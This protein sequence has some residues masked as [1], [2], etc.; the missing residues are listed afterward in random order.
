MKEGNS[1]KCKR[2]VTALL[3]CMLLFSYSTVSALAVEVPGSN[4]VAPRASG[5]L[6]H[7]VS[8]NS[9]ILLSQ[10]LTYL[11]GDTIEYD[12]TYTPEAASVDFGVVDSNNVFHYLNCTSGSIK[13]T[14]EITESGRYILAIRNNESYVVTVT[15]TVRY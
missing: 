5:V 3:A 12:C 15:G 9:V 14:I 7:K 2:F 4:I 1:M 8:A 11:A 6:N 10:S 13:K